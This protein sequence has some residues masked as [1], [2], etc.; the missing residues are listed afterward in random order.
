MN[1]T[2]VKTTIYLDPKIKKSVQ[3]YALRD[4]SSLS[5][6]I[7]NKLYEYLEDMADA[8]ALEN[9]RN[10]DN[11]YISFENIVEDLGLDLNEIR[12]KA[13]AE[14]QKTVKKTR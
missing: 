1:I 2:N 9:E 3:Y 4:S 11:D 5:A 10:N 6:I 8:V 14:R 13:Q 7:N 12:N